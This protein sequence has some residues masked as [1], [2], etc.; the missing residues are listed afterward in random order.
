MLHADPL[1]LEQALGNLLDNAR[2]YGG[3]HLELTA[4]AHEGGVRFHVRDDGAG[5]PEDLD[6]FERFTRG[7][8][9]RGRGG[10]GLGLAIVQRLTAA[11]GG[12]VQA[13]NRPE[14]GARFVVRLPRRRLELGRDDAAAELSER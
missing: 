14:G 1:R 10:A 6:A 11:H 8:S 9:A 3:E 7:D 4:E 2:R 12:S 13:D 5:F